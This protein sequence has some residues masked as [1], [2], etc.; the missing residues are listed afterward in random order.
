M[1]YAA[2]DPFFNPPIID[3]KQK[4]RE[5]I[6]HT[7]MPDDE[8]EEHKVDIDEEVDLT[9]ENSDLDLSDG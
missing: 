6:H 8:H 3:L 9:E 4:K 1:C 7:P 5:F 2:M